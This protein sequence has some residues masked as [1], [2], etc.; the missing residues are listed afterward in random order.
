MRRYFAPGTHFAMIVMSSLALAVCLIWLSTQQPWLGLRLDI[1]GTGTVV[2]ERV[3]ANGPLPEALIGAMTGA[4]LLGVAPISAPDQSPPP[5]LLIEPNDLIEE[6][7]TLGSAALLRRFYDRQDQIVAALRGGPVTLVFER[8]GVRETVT[9]QAAPTRPLADLPVKLWLQ[10]FVALTGTLVGAWVV[11]LR[12]RDWAAWMVLVAG[13]GLAMASASA[14][15]YSARELALSAPLFTFASRVNSSGAL[16]FGIGMVTLF[17]IYPRRIVP[18]AVLWLPVGAISGCIAFIQL[19]DWPQHVG[20]LQ[21][22]IAAIMVVLLVAILAQVIVNRRDPRARAMLGWLG[23]SIGVGAGGFVLTSVVPALLN[24]PP[25][26]EQS[27][28]F[29]FFLLIYVGIAMGVLR[30]RLFDLSRWSFGFMFYGFGVALLLLLDAALI[31]GLSLDRAPA[32]G[33]ALAAVGVVYLPLREAVGR[34][35]RRNRSLPAEVL[36]KRITEI[37]HAMDP[38][39]QQGLLEA[40]WGDLFHPLKVTALEQ[41]EFSATALLD[42]GAALRLAPIAGLPGLRLE[43]A[44]QGARLFSSADLG[45]AKTLNAMIARSLEQHL[46]YVEAITSERLRINRDMHDNIGVLLLGALHATSPDRKDLLIRQTLSDLREIISNPDQTNL[47]LP[48]LVADLRAE[49]VGHLEAAD[50]D[51]RWRDPVLPNALLPPQIVHTLR[52]LLRESTSNIVRHSGASSVEIELSEVSGQLTVTLQDDG[53]GFEAETVRLGNGFKNLAARVGQLGGT[54]DI[55]SSP[56]GT[57]ISACLPLE[58]RPHGGGAA[59]DWRGPE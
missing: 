7:D 15:L 24:L 43:W 13:G 16:I 9:V 2:I 36:Y 51:A 50:I 17:L 23:M 10:L 27:T 56:L 3:A 32:L 39:Q 14:A 41:G 5:A 31:Y 25:F 34:W 6:P 38:V 35:L 55:S 53:K 1:D 11:C 48:Q 42:D 26:L 40:F 58:I 12:P 37:A 59:E 49:I 33:I 45:R 18:R 44:H 22:M 29:L 46:E 19:K 57:R 54:F 4:R 28:A 21:D 30:Y 47:P 52:A 8:A 20:L